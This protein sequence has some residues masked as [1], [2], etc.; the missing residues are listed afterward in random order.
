LLLLELACARDPLDA[1]AQRYVELVRTVEKGEGDPEAARVL[2]EELERAPPSP[3]ARYLK[4]Q[5]AAMQA[6]LEER[7]L[8][9]DEESKILYGVVAPAVDEAES[10]RVREELDRLLPGEGALGPRYRAFQERFLVSS[11]RLDPVLHRALGESR[12]RV[13]ER[14]TL[15]GEERVRLELVSGKPWPSFSSYR[16][17]YESL[18]QVSRDF[19]VSVAGALRIAAHE[20]YP[21]HHTIAVLRDRDLVRGRGFVEFSVEPPVGPDALFVEGLSAYAIEVAFPREERLSFEKEILFPLAGLDPAEAE[22]HDAI[23]SLVGRLEPSAV[24]GARRYLN[25]DRD[26]V[27]SAIWLEKQ[28]AVP[29]PWGFLR[30]VDRYRT[31][32]VTYTVG[33][34]LVRRRVEKGLDPWRILDPLDAPV[35]DDET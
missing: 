9:F 16:G 20:A 31:Y 27:A 5:I 17:G 2:L 33:E 19:P 8:H 15:P 18:V 3:R 6:R 24:D 12:R 35:D 13:R 28:A 26:R 34:D 7:P 14:W 11:D 1:V 32:V 10:R 29:D 30:F 25:G 4:R 23:E 21:G 22:L